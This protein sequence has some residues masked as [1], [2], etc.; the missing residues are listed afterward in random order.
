[1]ISN[2]PRPTFFGGFFFFPPVCT[3]ECGQP[4][5]EPE[6]RG[7]GAPGEGGGRAARK[8]RAPHPSVTDKQSAARPAC[9]APSRLLARRAGEGTGALKEAWASACVCPAASEERGWAPRP[10][11]SRAETR[12]PSPSAGTRGKRT[13]AP[14]RRSSLIAPSSPPR[15]SG[16]PPRLGSQPGVGPPSGYCTA[17]RGASPAL[18]AAIPSLRLQGKR[19]SLSGPPGWGQREAPRHF[20]AGPSLGE[21]TSR[22]LLVCFFIPLHPQR[23]VRLLQTQRQPWRGAGP[24][25]GQWAPPWRRRPRVP[26]PQP[27]PCIL[28]WLLGH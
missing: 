23:Q 25:P 11:S 6:R 2:G 24:Q 17:D 20:R 1:M 14:T 18:P 13:G 3:V 28:N 12:P 16:S 10:A 9:A 4:A 26:T 7:L 8:V 22:V 15:E 5:K 19:L 21:R 27:R